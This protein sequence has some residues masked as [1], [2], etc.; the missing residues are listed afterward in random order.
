MVL[1][2]ANRFRTEQG[3]NC[4][5]DQHFLP[6]YPKDGWMKWMRDQINQAD[7]VLMVCTPTY[8]DRYERNVEES[9]NGVGFEGLVISERLYEEY[10]KSL[11][12]VPVICDGGS[13]EYVTHELRGR[14]IYSV[15]SDFQTLSDLIK[16]KQ[17]NPLPPLGEINSPQ[18]SP[19]KDTLT[20]PAQSTHLSQRE[21]ELAYLNNLLEDSDTRFANNNYITLSG[22]FQA[23]QRRIPDVFMPT[24][25]RHHAH[26]KDDETREARHG[27]ST[28][29]TDLISA[30][31][32]YK[33]LV[34][35]GEPGAGKTFSLWKIAADTAGKARQSENQPIPVIIPLNKWT[36]AGQPLQTFVLE[37]MGELAPYFNDLYQQQRLLPLLDA[38]NEIPFDQRKEKLPQVKKWIGQKFPRLLLSCRERDYGGPLVQALDRLDIEPLDPPRIYDFL[39]TYFDVLQQGNPKGKEIANQ[40]FWQLAGGKPMKQAWEGWQDHK[41]EWKVRLNSV[42]ANNHYYFSR[43]ERLAAIPKRINHLWKPYTKPSWKNFWEQ[44]TPEDWYWEHRSSP[45][46][47]ERFFNDPRCL[48]KLAQNP[49]LLNLIICIYGANQ[50]QLPQ[51]RYQL[52]DFFVSDLLKREVDDQHKA[53]AKAQ[54]PDQKALLSNLKR[55]AWQLQGQ[56]GED[57][58]RTTLTRCEVTE[59]QT[60]SEEQLK[61]AAAAS[62]LELTNDTVRFSHQLLQEYFTAQ[63]FEARIRQGL[64][65]TELWQPEN[66]W[67]PNGWEEAAKLAADY[68]ADPSEFLHWLAAGNPR[69]AVEIARDQSLLDNKDSLFSSYKQ[70]WQAAIINI[71]QY[72]NPHERHA[73]STTLAWLAWDERSGIG[74][75]ESGLPDID[76]LEVPKGDFI[77]GGRTANK[78]Y[79]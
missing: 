18:A 11:K 27:E 39:T 71:E 64:K 3:I 30:F 38:L 9:G 50:Q 47:R 10:F 42:L 21:A 6:A 44:K 41:P 74:L 1:D 32:H 13:L 66:W 25:F 68:E 35:L 67:E 79:L 29:C 26:P 5:I 52:F 36:A 62:L 70:T 75:T 46:A 7:F 45:Q 22:D 2:L 72:P 63:S 59:N 34:I 15:P 4:E 43:K 76:W 48:M 55:L 14:N 24:S 33:R 77:Y 17:Y 61:F 53:Q 65:A 58:A 19:Q 73:I 28:H 60:M 57:E 37:Q 23:D 49:Y 56:T 40:L 8:R 12:F 16:G 78:H 31:E 69:L 20:P 54:I 51:S